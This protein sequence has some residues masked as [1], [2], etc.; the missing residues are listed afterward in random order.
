MFTGIIEALGEITEVTPQGSGARVLVSAPSRLLN[1]MKPGDSIAVSGCCLTMTALGAHP[2][3]PEQSI[4]SADLARETVQ[5]TSLRHA[6][7]GNTVNLER[8]L[9]AGDLL[10]GHL[11]QGHVEGVGTLLGLEPVDAPSAPSER[12]EGGWWLSLRVPADLLPYIVWKGSLTIE[13]ISLTVAQLEG[14]V[15]G[16]AIIPFT[17]QHTNLRTLAPGSALNLE[18]DPLAR[19]V[20]RLLQTRFAAAPPQSP[21]PEPEPTPALSIGELRRQGF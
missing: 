6:H 15:V 8:P 19:H 4:F 7:A 14:D 16:V 2:D 10:S 11:V 3:Q 1:T 9:R 20:E 17:R 21:A 12:D 18:T 13:G 5:R